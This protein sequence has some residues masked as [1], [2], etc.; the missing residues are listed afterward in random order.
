MRLDISGVFSVLLLACF[1]WTACTRVADLIPE[2]KAQ[3]VVNCVLTVAD[4]QELTLGLTDIATPEEQGALADAVVTLYDESVGEEVGRF[5]REANEK[6]FLDYTAI[7]EHAYRLVVRMPGREDIAATTTMPKTFNIVLRVSSVLHGWYTIPHDPSEGKQPWS[8]PYWKWDE[9]ERELGSLYKTSSLPEGS[10][11]IIGRNYDVETREHKVAEWLA[12]SL[13][14]VDPFNVTDRLWQMD[15][16]I[17][18][19]EESYYSRLEELRKEY[20]WVGYYEGVKG[21]PIHDRV[22]RIPPAW[23]AARESAGNPPG[24]FSIYGPIICGAPISDYYSFSSLSDAYGYVLF[25][26]PSEEYDRFLKEAFA[27]GMQQDALSGYSSLFSRKNIYTNVR[28]GLGVFGAITEQ[29]L[30][31]EAGVRDGWD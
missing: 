23:E 29:R 4:K 19:V 22:L 20:G 17:S 12:T 18:E 13:L 7:P 16:F 27:A 15:S 21:R 6:W 5:H 9:S 31:W 26:A 8:Y 14:S 30:P 25:L 24:W 2:G 1:A 28:N 10:C 3:V 11:W